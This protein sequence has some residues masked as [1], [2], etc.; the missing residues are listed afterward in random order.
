MSNYESQNSHDKWIVGREV[1]GAWTPLMVTSSDRF[2]ICVPF[3]ASSCTNPSLTIVRSAPLLRKNLTGMLATLPMVNNEGNLGWVYWGRGDCSTLRTSFSGHR[4]LR[5][6][7]FLH[8][9]HSGP[10]LS[11]KYLLSLCCF[12]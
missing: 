5:C 9:K 11:S 4:A 1:K 12:R 10:F 6:P 2:M 7:Q 8:W 3:L